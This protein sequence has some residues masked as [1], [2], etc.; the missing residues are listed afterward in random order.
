VGTNNDI[1]QGIADNGTPDTRVALCDGDNNVAAEYDITTRVPDTVEWVRTTSALTTALGQIVQYV[2]AAA[3]LVEQARVRVRK[4]MDKHVA[5]IDNVS[6]L[7]DRIK[8][9]IGQS[10]KYSDDPSL[11]TEERLIDAKAVI[12]LLCTIIGMVASERGAWATFAQ[13]L[14]DEL[15]RVTRPVQTLRHSAAE[16]LA[17]CSSTVDLIGGTIGRNE[18]LR[19][20]AD[21]IKNR[22]SRARASVD[23]A[24]KFLSPDVE[25]ENPIVTA[26][27]TVT[28]CFEPAEDAEDQ[29]VRNY[30]CNWVR[31]LRETGIA[32]E[33]PA[34]RARRNWTGLHTRH[35]LKRRIASIFRNDGVTVMETLQSSLDSDGPLIRPNGV[36]DGAG[37]ES[38]TSILTRMQTNEANLTARVGVLDHALQATQVRVSELAKN[39][40]AW[41]TAANS[42]A[43]HLSNF[44]SADLQTSIRDAANSAFQKVRGEKPPMQ[45]SLEMFMSGRDAAA[46][47]GERDRL[48]VTAVQ[49]AANA[50]WEAVKKHAPQIDTIFPEL[51]GIVASN[52]FQW[53]DKTDVA[54]KA[55]VEAIVNAHITRATYNL[56]LASWSM[57]R[58][59]AEHSRM[60][61]IREDTHQ[62]LQSAVIRA[63]E[64]YNEQAR[65]GE[66]MLSRMDSLLRIA[67]ERVR[68]ALLKPI[69]DAHDLMSALKPLAAIDSGASKNAVRDWL[70]EVERE[71]DRHIAGYRDNKP[72][73]LKRI[74][75]SMETAANAYNA[76]QIAVREEPAKARNH[77]LRIFYNFFVIVAGMMAADIG[78]LVEVGRTNSGLS[79]KVKVDTFTQVMGGAASDRDEPD[80]K[81]RAANP[82]SVEGG[83]SAADRA[84]VP[85]GVASIRADERMA[86]F[87]WAATTLE[88]EEN[89]KNARDMSDS[90]HASSDYLSYFLTPLGYAALV[91]AHQ[92][93]QSAPT[94]TGI[95]LVHICNS[96]FTQVPFASRVALC[97]LQA[98]YK[99]PSQTA[100]HAQALKKLNQEFV[101][102]DDWWARVRVKVTSVKPDDQRAALLDGRNVIV[103][104][105][106]P[107]T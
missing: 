58:A 43:L 46:P 104:I 40:A 25:D 101:A 41:E 63:S 95:W 88:L 94:V 78:D 31:E 99:M 56:D 73:W 7:T 86:Q 59:S 107:R 100:P 12:T 57:K 5:Y 50:G 9:A 71:Y 105:S 81:A 89:K 48:I 27:I 30:V 39:Q 18:N 69:K 75:T 11:Q 13:V 102:N 33:P 38:Y 36:G 72:D 92:Y 55:V 60:T 28:T 97:A 80:A 6:A 45:T 82:S 64:A 49:T 74:L 65:T 17:L 29:D 37:T 3:D 103:S 68:A 26:L 20:I 23:T 1:G 34:D 2:T 42:L 15:G 67:D 32:P 19:N 91:Q 83:G 4:G 84:V 87:K 106:F 70:D 90:P 66:A 22:V 10:R 54:R 44:M 52:A 98:M 93:A 85:A 62:Q 77:P 76:A 35:D 79:G 24:S 61:T 21:S 47:R 51:N 16:C 96:R 53:P 8:A 14:A